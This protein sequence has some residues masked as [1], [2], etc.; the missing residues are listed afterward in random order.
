MKK[1]FFILAV[2]ISV[3]SSI[4]A[5]QELSSL[6]LKANRIAMNSPSELSIEFK[7]NVNLY[8]DSG[9]LFQSTK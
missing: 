3:Y 2:P 5:S 8:L 7:E 4:A 6:S 9:N 1:Y